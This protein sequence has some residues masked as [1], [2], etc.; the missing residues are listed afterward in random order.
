[1]DRKGIPNFLVS[2]VKA[3]MPSTVV[4]SLMRIKEFWMTVL[5]HR[6]GFL[7]DI[8][9]SCQV[10]HRLKIWLARHCS[11]PKCLS[12][13]MN[14]LNTYQTK[15]KMSRRQLTR[16]CLQSAHL[17]MIPSLKRKRTSQ[18]NFFSSTQTSMNLGVVL[19]FLYRRKEFHRSYIRSS[20]RSHHQAT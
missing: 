16:S 11:R 10:L 2:C 18:F 8:K 14:P 3:F 5:F 9:N 7:L 12:S 17:R 19:P 20:I 15:V 6:Y 13:R 1:M 4:P